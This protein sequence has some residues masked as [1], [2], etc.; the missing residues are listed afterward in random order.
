M[1]RRSLR[2]RSYEPSYR[3]SLV[4]GDSGTVPRRVPRDYET[5]K[6]ATNTRVV[7]AT[8]GSNSYHGEHGPRRYGDQQFARSA[9][10]RLP[11]NRYPPLDNTD[12]DDYSDRTTGQG[13]RD[14]ER[15]IQQVSIAQ[16]CF[17]FTG[18][19]YLTACDAHS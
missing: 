19:N 14:G 6:T 15:R 18:G 17:T 16:N 9:S 11:R 1:M 2:D 3:D 8:N 13:S 12:D 4:H 10:A 5:P 7:D